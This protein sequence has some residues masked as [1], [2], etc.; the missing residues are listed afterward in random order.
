MEQLTELKLKNTTKQTRL[1]GSK[2]MYYLTMHAT[3]FI[4]GYMALDIW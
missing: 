4:Y 2:K 1:E 3:H